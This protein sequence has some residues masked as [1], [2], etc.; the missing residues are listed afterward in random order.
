V[1]RE[2]V[3]I[4]YETE[5]RIT[6]S[7]DVQAEG[8]GRRRATRT[9][10]EKDGQQRAEVSGRVADEVSDVQH[11]FLMAAT[12]AAV[13][14]TVSTTAPASAAREVESRTAQDAG[15]PVQSR[16]SRPV[17]QSYSRLG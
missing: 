2:R 16:G 5:E 9:T 17:R 12:S 1:I 10:E 8:V 14:R 11:T 6:V 7:T 3:W 15:P 13:A 4:V